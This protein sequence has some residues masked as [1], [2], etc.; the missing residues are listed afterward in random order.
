VTGID[1]FGGMKNSPGSLDPHTPTAAPVPYLIYA[2]KECEMA[3]LTCLGLRPAQKGLAKGGDWIYCVFVSWVN[4]NAKII[5]SS[6]FFFYSKISLFEPKICYNT[7]LTIVELSANIFN[8][9]L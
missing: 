9:V 7:T 6:A 5:R 8:A 1:S 3:F 4:I 2:D